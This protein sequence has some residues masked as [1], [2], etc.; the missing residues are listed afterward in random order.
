[1]PENTPLYGEMRVCE[2]LD[3]RGRLHGMP[4]A[5]RR[6]RMDIVVDRCGL[7]GARRRL[8]GQLS[9]GNRQ[10]VGLAAALLHDP[11]VLI[12]DEPTAGLD[13]NQITEVRRLLKELSG[14]HT[15]LVSTH[16]L[17]EVEKIADRIM[18]IARG[19]IVADGLLSELRNHVRSGSR[20]IVEV[21]APPAAVTGAFKK[22]P[23]VRDVETET[24]DGWC[25]AVVSPD[26]SQDV[27]PALAHAVTVAG[28]PLR[29]IRY[30]QA[31]LERFFIQITAEQDQAA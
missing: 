19:R 16:I 4:R 25:R 11:P 5:L 12:L 28:W 30:E 21:T 23:G 26:R 31:S 24:V 10:R 7:A 29:E 27:R 22:L 1:M 3:F 13:P 6:Q 14:S 20:I 8:V 18:F 17:P 2:Y 15:I 9:R